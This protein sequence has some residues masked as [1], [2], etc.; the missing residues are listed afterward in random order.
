[1][2]LFLLIDLDVEHW[3]LTT[4]DL[5][6]DVLVFLNAYHKSS[7]SNRMLVVSARKILFDSDKEDISE[8]Y[9]ITESGCCYDVNDLGYALCLHRNEPSQILIFTLREETKDE[10]LRYLKCMSAAQRFKIRIDAFSLFDNKTI[11]QC[12]ASTGG[13]Y[14]TSEDDCL[15]FLLSILGTQDVPR[16]LGFPAH[17]YCHDKQVL[18]GLVCPVCLSVF[19]KF[20]PVCRRCKS[21]FS[22]IK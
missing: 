15:A 2:I 22:F 5:L 12:C 7:R 11:S 17:C 18:L 1:M 10:Y 4:R 13:S 20:V 21:K 19:C 8:I 9:R 16:P 3:R 6:N 14:S